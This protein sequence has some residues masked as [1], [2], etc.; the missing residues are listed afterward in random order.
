M[1]A[2]IMILTTLLVVTSTALGYGAPLGTSTTLD[3]TG[4]DD[5]VT[6]TA[7]DTFVTQ[8]IWNESGSKI[9][10]V[11]VDVK[12]TDTS[13]HTFEICV[14]GKAGGSISD[15][16]GTTADCT[17]TGSIASGAI[18]SATINFTN[19]LI[20]NNFDDTDISIEQTT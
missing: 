10:S 6:V 7:A 4:S 3:S 20:T 14:I 12:N 1:L 15:T 19:Q 16:V 11:T 9:S 13:A 5:N 2:K 8:I 17:S 18:G